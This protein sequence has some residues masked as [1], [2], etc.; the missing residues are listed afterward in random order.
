[1]YT[2]TRDRCAIAPQVRTFGRT[3]HQVS[4]LAL[5]TVSLACA[6]GIAEPG[7]TAACPDPN[8]A[9][10]VIREARAHG[11]SLF[12]TAPAYGE[13]E[14]LLGRELASDADCTITTKLAPPVDQCGRALEGQALERA[15][16]SS[17]EASLE[18]L[19]RPRIDVLLIHNATLDVLQDS[20]LIEALLRLRKRG[21]VSHLGVSVYREDEALAAMRGDAF[22]VVQIGLSLLDQRPL[23][24]VLP[25][26]QRLGIAIITRSALLKGA[27]TSRARWLSPRLAHVHAAADSAR[28]A[29]EVSWEELPAI[30][31]RFCLGVEGVS[32]TLI[33]V[34]DLDELT[35]ALRAQSDGPLPKALMSR[36]AGLASVDPAVVNPALWDLP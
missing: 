20:A 36:T 13:A 29:L 6:Y 24:R 11:I 25:T 23:L 22:D 19:A 12:D 1:M 35:A 4:A 2:P 9:L 18:R 15:V 32:S 21:L 5:G 30:A 27:L 34:H 33:G 16:I 14:V 3:G 28:R 10:R 8:L 26:A 17:V 7:S 31:L